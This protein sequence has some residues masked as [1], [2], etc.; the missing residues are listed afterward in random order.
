MGRT[1]QVTYMLET[2]IAMG[3]LGEG[4]RLPRES[5]FSAELGIS[6]ITLRQ[7]LNTLRMKGVI[8]TSRGRSGGSVVQ[9]PKEPSAE[10]IREKLLKTSTEDLRDMWDHCG[11]V[12]AASAKLAA[13][14][15]DDQDIE[16]LAGL[17]A[18]FDRST[19]AQ[20]RRRADTR[21][22]VTLGVAAQSS[23]L[24][25]AMLQIQ[26]ELSS[27][28]WIEQDADSAVAEATREHADILRCIAEHDPVAAAAAAELHSN[29]EMERIIKQHLQMLMVSEEDA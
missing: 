4:E 10:D 14:R 7:A 16:Y 8:T 11:A 6:S 20:E 19:T 28:L 13:Q 12:A 9:K 3:I 22:H 17:A 29:S 2:A 18:R 5:V 27:F 1:E 21:F 26:A 23:R 24:T 15:A 25:A